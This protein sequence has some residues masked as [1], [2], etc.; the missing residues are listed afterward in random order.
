MNS[1]CPREGG[2]TWTPLSRSL[3]EQF[4]RRHYA[5]TNQRAPAWSAPPEPLLRMDT[6]SIIRRVRAYNLHIQVWAGP[7]KW[8]I[9]VSCQLKRSQHPDLMDTFETQCLRLLQVSQDQ[10]NVSITKHSKLTT[11]VRG[12]FLKFALILSFIG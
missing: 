6:H 4:R 5:L 12:A 8:D 1:V 2:R 7:W 11:E 10:V 9:R 3:A